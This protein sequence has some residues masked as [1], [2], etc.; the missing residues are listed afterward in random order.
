MLYPLAMED[1]RF[2]KSIFPI[3]KQSILIINFNTDKTGSRHS[4]HFVC[5]PTYFKH[6]EFRWKKC[7]NRQNELARLS[8]L[9]CPLNDFQTDI[10][11]FHPN[12]FLKD[13]PMIFEKVICN[14]IC[15][16]RSGGRVR[17]ICPSG[18]SQELLLCVYPQVSRCYLDH[19]YV[20][21]V[22]FILTIELCIH[23]IGLKN[24]I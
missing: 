5:L 9:R 11:T 8:A 6:E 24:K 2:G 14:G 10:A 16:F 18:R 13:F 17:D 20:K 3:Y 23:V 22:I 4:E 7:R 1:S 21:I 19:A 15:H 12:D